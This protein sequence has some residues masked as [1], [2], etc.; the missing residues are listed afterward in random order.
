MCYEVLSQQAVLVFEILLYSRT[1][2]YARCFC[3]IFF[4]PDM[5]LSHSFPTAYIFDFGNLKKG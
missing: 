5:T 3:D 1:G 2:P 4:L